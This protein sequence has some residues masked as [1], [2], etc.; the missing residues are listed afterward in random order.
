MI[1]GDL[2]EEPSPMVNDPSRDAEQM[3]SECFKTNRPPGRRQR[4]PLHHGEDIVSQGIEPPPSSI[5]KESFSGHHPCCEVIFED[6]V[7]FF[8]RSTAF[9]LPLQQPFPIPTPDIGDN[10]KVMI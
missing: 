2:Q 8:Y 7:G 4:F 3:I 6:I 9:P 1:F 10:G 5:G